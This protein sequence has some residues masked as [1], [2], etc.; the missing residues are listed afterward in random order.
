MEVSVRRV[1]ECALLLAGVLMS[2]VAGARVS[3]CLGPHAY[4]IP[5]Q[6]GS[7]D[8]LSFKFTWAI[9]YY[10]GLRYFARTSVVGN[11]ISL[12]IAMGSM[13]PDD[14]GFR[15][16]GNTVPPFDANYD[17]TFG[18]VGPL[19]VGDYVLR[20][21]VGGFG[22]NGQGEYGAV[23]PPEEQSITVSAQA[24][25]TATAS[26]VEYYHA[27][28]DHYFIT[29]SP[30]EIADL[31]SVRHPGWARTG[32][33]FLAYLPSQSNGRGSAVCRW[34]GSSP[35]LDTHF[36]SATRSGCWSVPKDDGWTE[37]TA[38]AF[39]MPL[40]D[41]VT[42]VC[43]VGSAPVFR[44]WNNRADSNHRYTTS[45]AEKM[46]MVARGYVAEGYGPD[47]VAMCAPEAM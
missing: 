25:P 6:P 27:Q 1:L 17:G 34:Y 4:A 37:E 19:P 22:D 43:P 35:N 36:F 40:P 29:Q 26:L 46:R 21:S 24:V 9:G 41:L 42:G 18:T 10:Y 5:L 8:Q 15:Y 45:A 7:S 44:L 32:L 39:E 16:V 30:G 14:S 31:D 38:N 20:V 47:A 33:S 3:P 12:D 28:L 13:A 2:S 11:V 23:C